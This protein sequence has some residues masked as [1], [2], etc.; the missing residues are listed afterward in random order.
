MKE[1]TG[2]RLTDAG[3]ERISDIASGMDSKEMRF[4]LENVSSNL[5]WEEL[6]KR[7]RQ[8]SATLK[9]IVELLLTGEEDKER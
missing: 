3:K 6:Q 1:C 8:R 7:E 4:F 5:L 9:K 2:N